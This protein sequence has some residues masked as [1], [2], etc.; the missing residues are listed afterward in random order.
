[1]PKNCGTLLHFD[2]YPE[3][4]TVGTAEEKLKVSKKRIRVWFEQHYD[5]KNAGLK[6]LAKV[7]I[8]AARVPELYKTYPNGYFDA[9]L[10][11]TGLYE[12]LTLEEK[13]MAGA[14]D[15]LAVW[16]VEAERKLAEIKK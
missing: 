15:A 14:A 5:Q 7:T 13:L 2:D 4:A 12:F 10:N 6:Y 8:P 9:K 16:K 1:M 11:G 3:D